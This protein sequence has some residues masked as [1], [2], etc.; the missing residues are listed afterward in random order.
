MLACLQVPSER[1][2]P[3]RGVPSRAQAT[4]SPRHRLFPLSPPG[5]RRASKPGRASPCREAPRNSPGAAWKALFLPYLMAVMWMSFLLLLSVWLRAKVT[6][7]QKYLVPAGIIAG[8]LGFALINLGWIGYPSPEGWVPLKVG[9]FGMISFHL[10]SFGFGIIRPRVLQH[11]HQGPQHDAHQ[12]RSVRSICCSGCSTAFRRP[13]A[14]GL[15][16]S[17]PRSP[18]PT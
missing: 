18:G 2:A 1:E 16:S 5:G 6:F 15:R 9:D 17:T 11:A 13:W 12:G 4:A 10:F 3:E 8:T 7:L 14:T